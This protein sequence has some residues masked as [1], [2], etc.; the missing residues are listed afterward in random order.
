[1]ETHPKAGNARVLLSSVFG[2]YSQ[3]DQFGSRAINPMELYQNQVTRAQGAFSPRIFHRSW[4]IM[5]IQENIS[6]PCTVLDFP[7]REAFAREV[8][9]H[10]YDVVGISSIIVNV[11][12]VREMC[13]MVRQLSPRSKV[14]VGGHVAAIPGIDQ[15]I[16]AD[17]IV[18]G[19]GIS[20]M[21]RYLG[22]DPNAPIRHPL[23]ASG[24]NFRIM[25]QTVHERPGDAAV[26]II[27][28]VGCPMGCNFCT[29]SSFFGG[30]GKFTNFYDT[31][32][33]LFEIMSQMERAMQARFFFMMDEN[34]LLHRRR[35][36]ELL[37]LMKE[38]NKSWSFYVFASANALRQYTIEELVELG[39]TWVWIGLES[40]HS[41]Y[42]KLDGTNT[43]EL[44][45]ELRRHGIKLLGSTI[46]GLEH[47]TPE[48]I[49]H[50]IEH[51]I[52]HQTDFHQFM[53]YTPVPGTP[54]YKQMLA[55]GRMLDGI[56]LADIHGQHKFN[57]RHA[58]ISRD[59]SK[60]FLDWAFLRDYELNGP[61]LYRI[62]ETMLQGW[63]RYRDHSDA[64]VRA[65][66]DFEAQPL[67]TWYT[68][69]LWVMERQLK[70]A[71]TEVSQRIH[72]LRLEIESEFGGVTR[73]MSRAVGPVLLWKHRREERRLKN[74]IVYEPP[75]FIERRNWG[76]L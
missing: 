49:G 73:W 55:E 21:R 29:T 50:E 25:G 71:N 56:D 23:I 38:H 75:V 15:M 22:E 26:T 9:G 54:L 58:A 76:A 20:W 44:A 19:E 3:D 33:E 57:F 28:S 39:V 18:Q 66:F 32:R 4:G 45:R 41:N 30:K 12:K 67:K 42:D 1:M 46:I 68:A 17:H 65:R 72:D 37:A 63:R 59:D 70:D 62:C 2:P 31:G 51:A 7:T 6:A 60:R 61:S 13:R 47:H 16:D 11:G 40:P 53:L 64:R 36:M 43:L 10:N 52:A 48:N 24:F 69:A 5:M 8:T 35:A 14:V 74:G 27:P 34:F